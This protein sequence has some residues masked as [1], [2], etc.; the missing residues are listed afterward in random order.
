MTY[1]FACRGKQNIEETP[2]LKLK[3]FNSQVPQLV[4]VY[5]WVTKGKEVKI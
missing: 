2:K 3:M 1:M 5:K 4:R